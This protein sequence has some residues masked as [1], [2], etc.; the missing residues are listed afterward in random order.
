MEI[1]LEEQKRSQPIIE[2]KHI[3][4]NHKKSKPKVIQ[5]DDLDKSS[6]NE[7]SL[8]AIES[9]KKSIKTSPIGKFKYIG[10]GGRVKP[11]ELYLT[12]VTMMMISIPT[13]SF[14][15]FM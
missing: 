3:K 13:F 4:Y 2:H 1:E 5:V 15:V 14:V 9:A 11:T 8:A 6:D 12:I 7:D 10:P